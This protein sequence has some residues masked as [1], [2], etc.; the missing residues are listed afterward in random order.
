MDIKTIKQIIPSLPPHI[1]VLMRGP[2]GVG[3]SFVAA[4]VAEALGLPFIDVR[5]STMQE[6]DVIGYPDL[7]AMKT[8]GV[9]TMVLPAWFMRACKEPCV[10]MLD[11]LNR[12]MPGVMQGFFQVVLDRHLGNDVEGMPV[13]LHPETRILA[14]VNAGNE[15]DVNDMDPALLRRFWVCDV[16]PTV[17]DWIEWAN[18]KGLDKVLVDFVRQNP[19]HWRVDPSSVEPGTVV[20]TPASWHRLADSLTHCGQAP[21]NLAGSDSLGPIF[22][23]LCTGFI[24]TEAAIAFQDFV[25]NF[26][27]VVSAEDIL[28]GKVKV[29]DLAEANA[30]TLNGLIDKLSDH[31]KDNQ[32]TVTHAKRVAAVGKG[33]GGEMMVHLWNKLSGTGN[34]KNIQKVHKL[35]GAEVVKVVQASRGLAKS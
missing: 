24:G 34:L 21:V 12:A 7:E 30:G 35:M 6:G 29:G 23:S 28:E 4:D 33:L 10:L 27:T 16:E 18:T 2:T 8:S 31:C 5:G 14:A 32:W 13:T 20:P 1:A 25:K 26:E 11:E 9:S 3:K 17:A 15:Y 19:V 22:Y